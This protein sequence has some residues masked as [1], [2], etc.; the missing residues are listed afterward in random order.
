[1]APPKRIR[2]G[3][4]AARGFAATGAAAGIKKSGAD[5]IAVVHS[6]QP[7]TTAGTFTTNAVRA[8][9]VDWN[10]ALLPARDI[11]AVVVNAGNANACTGRQGE[12]DVEAMAAQTATLLSVETESVLVASTGVIGE[13]LPMDKVSRGIGACTERL[14][15]GGG[16]RFA[17]A[18]LTTDLATKEYAVQTALSGG[19][20]IVGGCAKGS[21]MIHPSMATM[22]G[23]ITT[24]AAVAPAALDR[25]VKRV[26]DATFNN[27]TIDGDTSTNDMVLVL[28]NGATGTVATSKA[29]RA[30]FEEALYEVCNSLCAKIAADGEGA[31]K[32]IEVR[33]TGA[34]STADTKLAAK[35]IA[36]SNLVKT[37]M[38]GGDPNWGRILC[39]VG[40]SGARFSQ[41]KIEVR[42]C[43]L[44]VC[45][46]LRPVSFPL[47]TMRTRLSRAVVPIEVNLGLGGAAEAVAHTCDLTY[48]YVKINAEYHT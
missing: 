21:G 1:M 5:D 22:L 44:P 11:H 3:I 30:L 26:V 37:A 33:V 35:A 29:D 27:L 25:A 47:S 18:I 32:R 13:F 20:V 28:A 31:T 23:F 24:D 40:Y 7:C 43:G 9:C 38:F 19:S 45:R 12:M 15:G 8:A 46:A 16:R 42:L 39:A 48:D 41:K 6:E 14:S 2:G 10:R 4:T 34:A 17:K 36:G